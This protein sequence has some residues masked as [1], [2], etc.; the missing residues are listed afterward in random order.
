MAPRKGADRAEKARRLAEVE[1]ALV[2][3]LSSQAIEIHFSKVWGVTS[4]QVHDYVREVR[5]RWEKEAVSDDRRAERSHMRASVNDLYTRAM[6][7]TEVV[8]D[9][10]GN[11][12]LGPDGQPLRVERPDFRAAT[13]AAEIL[14][15]LDGLYQDEVKVTGSLGA[16]VSVGFAARSREDLVHF[17]R[18]GRWPDEAKEAEAP[19]TH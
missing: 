18:T 10:K 17:A 4:R 1:T 8:R 12:M 13:R 6:S 16:S 9:A 3:R 5:A 7:K 14:C 19:A 15:R 11:V 2:R